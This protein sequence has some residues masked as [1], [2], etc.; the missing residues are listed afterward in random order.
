MAEA[1]ASDLHPDPVCKACHNAL[2]TDVDHIV[3]RVR[4]G[5]DSEGS[6]QGLC[7]ACHNRKTALF[8]GAFKIKKINGNVFARDRQRGEGGSKSWRIGRYGPAR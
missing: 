4:G 3:A 8:D 5:V 6:L 7:H 1:T 2:S